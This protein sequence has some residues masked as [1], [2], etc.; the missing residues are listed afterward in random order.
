MTVLGVGLVAAAAEA[1]VRDG[2]ACGGAMRGP[3]V[4]AELV[5]IAGSQTNSAAGSQ[6][7]GDKGATG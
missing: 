3:P 1:R 7:N 2:C 4:G 5:F 6:S